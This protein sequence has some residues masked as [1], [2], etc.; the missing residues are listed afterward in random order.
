MN[1]KTLKILEYEKIINMLVDMASSEPAKRLCNKL[2]PSTDISEI[3]N[4]TCVQQIGAQRQ[5]PQA[6]VEEQNEQG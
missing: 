3:Q 4:N 6:T 2:Q 5:K 1:K